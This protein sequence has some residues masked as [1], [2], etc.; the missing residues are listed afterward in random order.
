MSTERFQMNVKSKD[1]RDRYLTGRKVLAFICNGFSV[2]EAQF[3]VATMKKLS[4][5]HWANDRAAKMDV[6]WDHWFTRAAHA[7][8]VF[9]SFR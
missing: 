5:L 3:Q 2:N 4:D 1:E 6:F 9:L 7:A 8:C